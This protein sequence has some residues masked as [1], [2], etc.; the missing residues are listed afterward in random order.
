[1]LSLV[2]VACDGPAYL[3]VDNQSESTYIAVSGDGHHLVVPPK[4][5]MNLAKFPFA[6]VPVTPTSPVE[7]FD[8]RCRSLG[9]FDQVGTITIAS[10]GAVSYTPDEPGQGDTAED[11]AF[12]GANQPGPTPTQ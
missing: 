2:L 3:N 11:S 12:C 8:S 9:V 6:G 10:D 1:M 5:K 4:R 7:L